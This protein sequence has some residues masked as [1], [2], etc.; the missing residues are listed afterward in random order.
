[1]YLTQEQ[2]DVLSQKLRKKHLRIELLDSNLKTIDSIEGQ[3]IGG[4]ITASADNDIR[5]S[6]NITVAIPS[7]QN[8]TIFLEQLDGFVVSIGGKIW[9]D[10]NIKISVGI[11]NTHTN[12]IVWY[13][14]GVFLI[15][16]PVRN[17]SSNSHTI[18][19]EC[20]DLMAKFTGK[21]QG[22]LT[23]TTTII[24]KGHYE[25][26]PNI[27]NVNLGLN[28]NF[29]RNSD[30]NYVMTKNSEDERFSNVIPISISANTAITATVKKISY[31]GT[32]IGWLQLVATFSD[33]TIGYL[34]FENNEEK[35][36]KT[37]PKD[38]VSLQFYNDSTDPDGTTIIFNN[39]MIEY[40]TQATPYQ[41]YGELY[42]KNRLAD[43]LVSTIRE[44]G[45]VNRYTIYPIPENYTYLP[46]DIKV[47][48]G[49][50]VYNILTELMA[51]IPTWEM[52]FDLDGVFVIRPIPSGKSG[53]VYDLDFQQYIS[54]NLSVDFENVKNQ[55]V[56]Y[57]RLNTL[58]YYTENSEE[59]PS[60]VIYR[61]NESGTS[62]T[63]VLKYSNILTS[64]LTISGTTFGFQSL[65][66]Y[67]SLPITSVEIYSENEPTPIIIAR[68]VKFENSTT[69]FDI[70]YE[71]TQVEMNAISPNDIYFIRIYNAIL[72]VDGFVDI[73][74][75]MTFEFMGKQQ[76]SYDLVNDNLESPFYINQGLKEPNYYAGL[77][78][79][80]L[81]S[82]VGE[83][84]LLTLNNTEP[85]ST[86]INGTI[87]T[88]QANASNVFATGTNFTFININ[89]AT[90]TSLGQ[91]IPIVQNV[92]NNDNTRP[93][94][95]ENKLSNDYTI[96]QLQYEIVG[97][98]SWFV[99]K[100]RLSTA[101][102]KILS[103]GEYD[104]IYADQLAFE[105]CKY[106]LFNSSNLQNSISLSV[107]PNYLLD[108]N[109][110]IAY[111]PNS[112][113]PMRIYDT[114][115]FS[116]MASAGY[117]QFVTANNENFYV[118]KEDLQFYITKQITYPLGIDNTPQMVSAIQIYESGN[119]VGENN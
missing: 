36:T 8:A 90:G 39:F 98:N 100:G 110:K 30:G 78:Q 50:T 59:E 60:N 113:L 27:I 1:M 57:G 103:G 75:P 105:R 29:T 11:E 63:L 15:N 48:V 46:Y 55:V 12:Q 102:T 109:C 7:N 86:L 111:N 44:L 47:G 22:Q 81:T 18:S 101:L 84:Y 64:T 112:S 108:V 19:F 80:P 118:R 68:L 117:E 114:Q 61:P 95:E 43:A 66:K 9:L 45:G 26:S 31:S 38:I 71:T 17:F 25:T 51:I 53:V 97:D 14:L 83:G 42:I 72:T 13:K 33:N 70:K 62:A 49:S 65:N 54:D 67:N 37:F 21:R 107:V 82:N 115:P 4:S 3:A 116:T 10:K 104:N 16:K 92:W 106:E 5:R 24:E 69:S 40:G 93:F 73:T 28:D 94:L 2:I 76:V 56:V 6:G 99:L 89:N 34:I 20:I 119:L 96:W 52:F 23:G 41:P 88:F 77:A 85:L 79:T 58:S 87:I 74:Q 91:N 35:I 32:Y